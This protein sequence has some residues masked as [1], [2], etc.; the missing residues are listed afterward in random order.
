MLI[1]FIAE[2][3][4]LETNVAT[5]RKN[6]ISRDRSI[7]N[8]R[9]QNQSVQAEN[10]SLSTQLRRPQSGNEARTPI[11]R[12]K[13]SRIIIAEEPLRKKEEQIQDVT[14]SA[15]ECRLSLDRET[16]ELRRTLASLEQSDL[17]NIKLRSQIESGEESDD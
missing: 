13:S 14:T 9:K 1:P 2:V 3:R 8:L 7:D 17:E 15:I 10:H 12:Q 11:V 16:A 4:A 5:L 6:A